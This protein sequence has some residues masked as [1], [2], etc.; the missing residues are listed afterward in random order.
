MNYT[1]KQLHYFVAAGEAGSVTRAAERVHV[2]QPSIS[3]AIAHLEEVFGLQLFIRHHAQ[4]LS[5]TPAGGRL[6]GEARRLLTQAEGLH[7]YASEL[8]QSLSGTLEVGCF[9]TLAPIVM[10]PLIKE[11]SGRYPKLAIR[12]LEAHHEELLASLL[13]GRFEV[14]LSYDLEMDQAF[15]F[16]P[17]ASFPPYA[18]LPPGHRLAK[19]KRISLKLLVDEPMI[20]LDL[21]HSRDYFRSIFL[22]QGLEPR[23]A[24]VTGSPHMVRGLV[25]NGFGYSLLNARIAGERA[26]DGG[27]VRLHSADRKGAPA[28]P[29]SGAPGAGASDEGRGR[30]R[31]LLSRNLGAPGLVAPG[32]RRLNAGPARRRSRSGQGWRRAS[33]KLTQLQ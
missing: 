4:G 25:A 19:R 17:I 3:A 11:L 27:K 26:L 30:L 12:C 5:L 22:T 23:V 24:Q 31:R 8:G 10:P 14:A 7:Q 32:L 20:L 29:R 9:I 16:E 15:R 28:A 13:Q 21:P 2:S 6:L 18:I 1:L 33:R